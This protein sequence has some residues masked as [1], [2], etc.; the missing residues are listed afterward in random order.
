MSAAP[1][2]T[3]PKQATRIIRRYGDGQRDVV[4]LARNETFEAPEPITV[5]ACA[6][7]PGVWHIS[8]DDGPAAVAWF[9]GQEQAGETD[10]DP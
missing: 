4:C 10:T 9:L 3:K 1:A 2:S 7:R 6:R 8:N 5:L